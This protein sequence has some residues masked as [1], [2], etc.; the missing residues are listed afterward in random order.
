[1]KDLNLRRF[2]LTEKIP[3]SSVTMAVLSYARSARDKAGGAV[4]RSDLLEGLLI[5]GAVAA[6]R[7]A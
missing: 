5:T 1:V 6:D 4:A 7:V 3:V 2:E